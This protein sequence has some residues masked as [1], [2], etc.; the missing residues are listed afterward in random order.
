MPRRSGETF[1]CP[2]CGEPVPVEATACPT[3]GSDE[4]T[5]WS[6]DTMYD[7]LDL[8]TGYGDEEEADPPGNRGF[9]AAVAVV[10]IIVFTLL[11]LAGVW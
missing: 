1:D 4:D 6:D 8:P 11:V 7:D 3:C 9:W 5:G 10:M 2:H